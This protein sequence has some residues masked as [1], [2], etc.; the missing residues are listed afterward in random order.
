M[1]CK[2]LNKL[3]ISKIG[4]AHILISKNYFTHDDLNFHHDKGHRL[5]VQDQIQEQSDTGMI[6][7]TFDEHL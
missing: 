1:T 2:E 7:Y 5:T 4:I 6:V 3:A